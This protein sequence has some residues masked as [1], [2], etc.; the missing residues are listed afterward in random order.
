MIG[1]TPRQVGASDSR[2]A[3]AAALTR[4]LVG[5]MT[6]D[7]SAD[8][9]ARN[10]VVARHV[11]NRGPDGGTFQGALGVGAR[12]DSRQSQTQRD[13]NELRFHDQS[14]EEVVMGQCARASDPP[15]SDLR[16]DRCQPA[17]WVR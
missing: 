11:A 10:R 4:G 16:D 2:G 17:A 13:T 5:A 6:A 8:G 14:F 7:R 9:G 3:H 12:G 15:R 1:S